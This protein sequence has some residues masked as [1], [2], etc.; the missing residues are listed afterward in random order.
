M[1]SLYHALKH[2]AIPPVGDFFFT[3][4]VQSVKVVE[5]IHPE[6]AVHFKLISH[7]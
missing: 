4:K 5:I 2:L 1:Q 3:M 6:A 7:F